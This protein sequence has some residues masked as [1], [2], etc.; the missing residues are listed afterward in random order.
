MNNYIDVHSHVLY[1]IDDGSKNIDESIKIL[2]QYQEMGFKNIIVTPHYIE[3]TTYNINNNKKNEIIKK[4]NQEI[5]KNNID[6]NIHIG[7]ELY[8]SNDILKLL[9]KKEIATL[10]NSKYLLMEL[11]MNNEIS[12][13]N[14]IIFELLSNDI[15]PIIAHPERYSYIQKNIKNAEELVNQGALLQINYGSI[16]GIYGKNAKKTTKKLLKNNLVSLLGTDI[17]HPN[18]ETY[19]NMDKIRKKLTKIVGEQKINELMI[20]NPSKILENSTI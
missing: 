3:E 15:I 12:N 17:H 20:K 19:T 16:I 7:N 9:N 11:P 4:L 14:N 13:L 18:S 8:I 6:I 1:G 2:K 10:N 5:K